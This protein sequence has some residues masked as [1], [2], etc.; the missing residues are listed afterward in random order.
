MAKFAY[1]PFDDDLPVY[2]ELAKQTAINRQTWRMIGSIATLM[3]IADQAGNAQ[4]WSRRTLRKVPIV[5][6][7]AGYRNPYGII[8]R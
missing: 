1:S 4:S 2:K 5:R 3:L 6:N 7:F 8:R